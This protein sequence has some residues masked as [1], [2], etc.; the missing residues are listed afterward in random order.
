[1]LRILV[2]LVILNKYI[3]YNDKNKNIKIKDVPFSYYKGTDASRGSIEYHYQ[4][5]SNV[6]FFRNLK[7]KLCLFDNAFLNLDI[8]D[9]NKGIL[10][11]M[12]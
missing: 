10:H 4:N 6:E 12:I 7:L 1:M 8:D 5:Y 11:Y 3:I 9:L 2:Q